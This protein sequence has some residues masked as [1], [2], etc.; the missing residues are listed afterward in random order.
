MTR[1][2][3]WRESEKDFVVK[4][5]GSNPPDESYVCKRDFLEAKR[6]HDTLNY[7]PKWK[8]S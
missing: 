3:N 8:N 4:H 7:I 2:V 1:F 6:H 5:L